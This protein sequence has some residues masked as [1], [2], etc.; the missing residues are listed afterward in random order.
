[1]SHLLSVKRSAKV[2]KQEPP[3]PIQR[4]VVKETKSIQK[5]VPKFHQF[6]GLKKGFFSATPK[7]KTPQI[8]H[9]EPS[10][11]YIEAKKSDP[12]VFKEVQESMASKFEKSR[13]EWMTPSFLDRI[14]KSPVLSKA[15]QDPNFLQMSQE[16]IKDP[17][18]TLKKCADSYPQWLAAIQEFAG[19]LGE[20][21]EA[22]A[23]ELEAKQPLSE[24]EQR[25]ID[26]V[27]KD[28]K[29]QDALKDPQVQSLL[30]QLQSNPNQTPK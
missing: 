18:T 12:L 30:A 14:E 23:D 4:P 21:F 3:K 9:P 7:S 26:R 1:M 27:Q 8:K 20:T 29:V 25:L 28:P 6:Q 10:L 11:T 22:K 19:L 2:E 13:S 15:F 24:F 17:V 16:L 5:E